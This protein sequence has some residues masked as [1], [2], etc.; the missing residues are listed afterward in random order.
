M[1]T[2]MSAA[3]AKMEKGAAP[4]PLVLVMSTATDPPMGV[5]FEDAV[6]T[7]SV[8]VATRTAAPFA[9]D[10]AVDPTMRIVEGGLPSVHEKR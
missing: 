8:I 9:L 6:V 4:A 1:L 2:T 10:D 3:P 7:C 5:S